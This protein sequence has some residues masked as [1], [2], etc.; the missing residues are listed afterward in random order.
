MDE[1]LPKKIP[2]RNGVI[3]EIITELKSPDH[4]IQ[5]ALAVKKEE[6]LEIPETTSNIGDD[7]FLIERTDDEIIIVEDDEEGDTMIVADAAI[8]TSVP[9]KIFSSSQ[10]S[11]RSMLLLP[12]NLHQS[13][14]QE[15][16]VSPKRA[17]TV[18]LYS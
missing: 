5:P 2:R 6:K 16:V 3:E 15:G 7:V 18:H 1:I 13:R 12:D 8:A 9:S 14:A 10:G 11:V 4:D 17:V